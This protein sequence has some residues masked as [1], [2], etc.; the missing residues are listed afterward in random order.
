MR[1]P[2]VHCLRWQTSRKFANN[3]QCRFG[4]RE[5]GLETSR[6][7]VPIIL[8]LLTPSGCDDRTE[9]TAAV[10]AV[11]LGHTEMYEIKGTRPL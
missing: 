2:Q 11:S 7:Q 10:S 6:L 1:I 8:L 4:P 3:D 9:I 5:P